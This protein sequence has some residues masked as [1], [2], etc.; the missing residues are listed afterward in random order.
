IIPDGFEVLGTG[1]LRYLRPNLALT[2]D[3]LAWLMTIVSDNVAA[4]LLLLE[5][6][7]PDAVNTTMSSLD[8]PTARLHSFDDMA[9]GRGFGLSS[10]RDL[11]ETYTHLDDRAR[12]MLLRQQDLIGLPRR[13][14]HHATAADF[15]DPSLR[16]FNK[17]GTGIGNFV[18]AGMFETPTAQWVVAV[19][20]ADQR[21]STAC[22]DDDA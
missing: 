9:A 1:V 13:L 14:H 8:L 15:A 10:A 3:D 18:D 17:T 16:V 12:R 20:T 7:G 6:G 11:A 5:V 21:G 4:A 19:M 2:L 22:P